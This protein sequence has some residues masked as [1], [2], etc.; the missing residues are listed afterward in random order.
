MNKKDRRHLERLWQKMNECAGSLLLGGRELLVTICTVNDEL[1]FSS[2]L[3]DAGAD[4]LLH[5]LGGQLASLHAFLELPD[6]LLH[7]LNLDIF[8]SLVQLLLDLGLL[9]RPD[10]RQSPSALAGGLQ[11]VR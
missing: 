8:L 7:Q 6:L 5:H 2:V 9:L 1:F 3:D 4:E 10:L 11:H